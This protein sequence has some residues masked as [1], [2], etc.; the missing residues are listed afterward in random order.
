MESFYNDN[1]VVVHNLTCRSRS[2]DSESLHMEALGKY[3]P[4][5][6]NLHEMRDSCCLDCVSDVYL[7]RRCH[8][9]V[10]ILT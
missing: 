1:V 5:D 9:Y 3:D 10:F 4:L 2:T 8:G 7:D 6:Y